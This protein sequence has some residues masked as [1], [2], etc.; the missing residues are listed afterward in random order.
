MSVSQSHAFIHSSP[1]HR[2]HKIKK[3]VV[4]HA[5]AY[6]NRHD[7]RY[8]KRERYY[9]DLLNEAIVAHS[10]GE[11]RIVEIRKYQALIKQWIS[12]RHTS[13]NF[14]NRLER[15]GIHETPTVQLHTIARKA[16]NK[17]FFD[18]FQTPNG[19]NLYGADVPHAIYDGFRHKF[20]GGP[21]LVESEELTCLLEN[22]TEVL[23]EEDRV[24]LEQ[25]FTNEEVIESLQRFNV[26]AATGPD[27]LPVQ[28]YLQFQRQVVP[29]LVAA[30][31][32]LWTGSIFAPEM[33]EAYGVLLHKKLGTTGTKFPQLGDFR[34]IT[35]FNTDHKIFM[36]CLFRRISMVSES[37]F[38]P[39]QHGLKGMRP[40][41]DLLLHIREIIRFARI[42][43]PSGLA[44]L[45]T[46]FTGAYDSIY[47]SFLTSVLHQMGFPK[48]MVM[49]IDQ[50]LARRSIRLL[51]NDW[52]S[53]NIPIKRGISQ[54]CSLSPL[55]F[56]L[57]LTPILNYV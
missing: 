7:S 50:I 4:Y 56:S 18:K 20:A 49:I 32:E 33:V 48:L 41:H 11:N 12:R 34:L 23:N 37:L 9:Y 51:I 22:I 25:P 5:K 54:G 47:H 57:T 39:M 17:Y 35:L 31:N 46:D 29:L 52:L 24:F 2:W 30:C 21:A 40:V 55:L 13:L 19:C 6:V 3:A 53:P 16:K 10:R 45:S 44:I 27:G 28:W 43:E 36:K 38:H 15:L 8:R 1:L 14:F 42:M 26:H